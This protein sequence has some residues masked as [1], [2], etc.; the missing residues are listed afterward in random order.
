MLYPALLRAGLATQQAEAT[1]NPQE[2][3]L[4]NYEISPAPSGLRPAALT[5]INGRISNAVRCVPPENKPTPQE[6]TTCNGF[7]KAEIAA[8]P[9]LKMILSLGLV[10]HNAVLKALGQKAAAFRFGHGAEHRIGNLTL[11]NSYHTSRYNMN[12]NRL[13]LPMFDAIIAQAQKILADEVNS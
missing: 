7:L 12:T 13:T 6:V 1:P 2:A 11:L 3:H 8:M 5:L 10:S 4:H 9:Q